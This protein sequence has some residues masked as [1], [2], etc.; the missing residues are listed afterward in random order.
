[1]SAF[2]IPEAFPGH[3]RRA[4]APIPPNSSAP[5]LR[6]LTPLFATLTESLQL[7]ENTGPLSPLFAT[8]TR[9]P[10]PKSFICHSYRKMGW[11]TSNYRLSLFWSL[12]AYS[13]YTCNLFRI[14][15]FAYHHPLTPFFS[16]LSKKGGEGGVPHSPLRARHAPL[17]LAEPGSRKHGSCFLRFV[18]LSALNFR[19]PYDHPTPI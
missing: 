7:V 5:S 4:V 18:R 15:S 12:L 3:V 13:V 1:M 19:L 17:A 6:A 10:A 14:T 16:H 8:L 9:T 2:C 11:G